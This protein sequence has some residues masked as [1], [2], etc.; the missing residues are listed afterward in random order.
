MITIRRRRGSR[1]AWEYQIYPSDH[2]DNLPLPSF[3]P[4]SQYCDAIKL[5]I[6]TTLSMAVSIGDEVHVPEDE[7]ERYFEAERSISQSRKIEGAI[8]TATVSRPM[9]GPM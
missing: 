5:A 9:P 8:A 6:V 7:W 1:G 4:A 2:T 3:H